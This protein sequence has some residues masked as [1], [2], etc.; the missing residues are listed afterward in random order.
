MLKEQNEPGLPSPLKCISFA[1]PGGSLV[2]WGALPLP[3]IHASAFLFLSFDIIGEIRGGKDICNPPLMHS[4]H[5]RI[6]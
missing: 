6:L 3:E 2:M 4:A 1:Q 5:T